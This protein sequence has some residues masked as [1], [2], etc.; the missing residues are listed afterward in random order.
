MT[1][2]LPTAIDKADSLPVLPKRA[3]FRLAG[4]ARPLQELAYRGYRVN[5]YSTRRCGLSY[6]DDRTLYRETYDDCD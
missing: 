1:Y 3:C 5:G 4:A 2:Y 6:P